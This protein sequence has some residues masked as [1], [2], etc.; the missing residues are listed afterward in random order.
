[1]QVHVQLGAARY[2]CR[3]TC[4]WPGA[5]QSGQTHPHPTLPPYPIPPPY[6]TTLPYH[7]TLP[8][9]PT[10]PYPT[11]PYPP[12]PVACPGPYT[13]GLCCPGFP[14]FLRRF[15]PPTPILSPPP[16]SPPD[17]SSRSL[18]SGN[19]APGATAGFG[20]GTGSTAGAGTGSG[21]GVEEGAGTGSETGVEALAKGGGAATATSPPAFS[22]ACTPLPSPFSPCCEPGSA[23]S[24]EELLPL[25][26]PATLAPVL[27]LVLFVVIVPSEVLLAVP[28][29][30]VPFAWGVSAVALVMLAADP[31]LLALPAVLF[32]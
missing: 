17:V 30:A 8:P 23:T 19:S 7:P 20:S 29:V 6:P 15:G 16:S 10:P 2:T 3:Y 27:L 11:L 18:F 22:S 32:C 21:T 31:K 26:L 25:L 12:L 4:S 24:F 13:C 9:Y 5:E 28:F 14:G 1:M